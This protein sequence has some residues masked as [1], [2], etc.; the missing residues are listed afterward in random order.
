MQSLNLKQ[1][2]A[3]CAVVE[4]G[5]FTAASEAL[6]LAQST[7]SG[8]VSALE[9]DLG[10]PLLVRSS[11]RR[12]T[13]TE[14]GRKVYAHA[15]SILQSC[16]ELSREL[17]EQTSQELTL[18]ASSIPMQYLLPRLVAGFSAIR[19]ECRFTLKDGDS[20]RVHRAVLEGE[21]QL[22]FVGAVLNMKELRYEKIAEDALVLA[23][24][25]TPRFRELY[26]QGVP[27]NTLLG[28]PL[29]FREGGSGTQ[30]AGQR[31]L[32]ENGIRA[33]DLQIV[34][35]IENSEAL[36]RAV[37]AGMGCAVVSGLAAASA[38]DVLSFPL[39]GKHPSRELYMIRP[40]D[41]RISK[42]ASAFAE[43]VLA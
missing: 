10:V 32:T 14:E 37:G 7:V 12:I 35:R 28:E 9:R 39:K 1:L 27:G 38:S 33:E 6:Y 30:I 20:E 16:G 42:I 25:D 15:R 21:A 40:L 23:A 4:K 19:P 13:L 31:F 18:A 36:L 34:A 26:K 3:F 29:L 24:P 41:R 5:S 2:E 8:H 11:K 17:E 43:Y 22:G